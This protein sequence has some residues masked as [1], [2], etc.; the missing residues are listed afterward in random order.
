MTAISWKFKSGANTGGLTTEGRDYTAEV[1]VETDDPLDTG[2]TVLEYLIAE[3]FTYGSRYNVGNDDLSATSPIL[4]LYAIEPPALAPGSVTIWSVML[5][6]QLLTP[7]RADSNGD[8]PSDPFT[9]RPEMSTSTTTREEA[10]YEAPYRG[11][12]LRQWI[13]GQTRMITNSADDVIIPPVVV[14]RHNRVVRIRRNFAAVMIN[15]T[16][17]PLHWINSE[18][19]TIAVRQ[20]TIQVPAYQIKLLGWQT[21]S[22]FE[23]G[24]DF[25]KVT[26]EGEVNEKGWRLQIQ[27]AGYNEKSSVGAT[28]FAQRKKTPIRLKGGRPSGPQL[29][30]G[31]GEVLKIPPNTIA[32][33]K[34]AIWSG[35]RELD[36]RT[37][38]F[39]AGIVQ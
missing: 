6:Y 7:E 23:D 16:N 34:F 27:D 17:L 29:L 21:E 5:R 9:V 32:D 39:F 33:A 26:F 25:V 31:D 30:N 19:F 24:F 28:S 20:Q 13:V 4:Y 15:D 1:W 14:T 35:Y 22:V 37:M 11:G 38:V 8:Q 12:L 10:I 36:V 3:G 18:A 2:H